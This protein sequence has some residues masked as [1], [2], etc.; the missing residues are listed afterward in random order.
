MSATT[1]FLLLASLCLSG[2]VSHSQAATYYVAK[3]GSDTTSCA[4]AQAPSTPRLTINRG[5]ACMR[6]GDTLLIGN[7]TYDE[8]LTDYGAFQVP[9][10][11]RTNHTP[12]PSGSAGA[13]TIL[14]AQ[15]SRQATLTMTPGGDFWA[16]I[17]ATSGLAYVQF[18]GFVIDGQNHATNGI[19]GDQP[20]NLRFYDLFLKDI[21]S[22]AVQLRGNDHQFL[23]IDME[24]IAW[25][26]A[27][28]S[29]CPH[30]TCGY[31]PPGCEGYCHAY[32]LGG[33][34]H[35]IDR[36]TIRNINGYLI[37]P[38]NAPPG[39]GSITITNVV[40]DGAS[41]IGYFNAG[42][43]LSNCTISNIY[44]GL[45]MS[46]GNTVAHNTMT[47]RTRR[48]ANDSVGV[49]QVGAG[50]PSMI[51]NNLIFGMD[52]DFANYDLIH[53]DDGAGYNLL[54]QGPHPNVRGNTCDKA[55][56]GCQ[57]VALAAPC[58]VVD[59]A[60]GDFRLCA[61]S[62]AIGAGVV[63]ATV[64]AMTP[65]QAGT[66]R[67]S[68][69]R[70]SGALG[71]LSTVSVAT[72]LAFRQQPSTTTL[73]QPF[74]PAVVVAVVDAAGKTVATSTAPITVALA[75][76]PGQATLEGCHDRPSRA[77]VATFTLERVDNCQWQYA[78]GDESRPAQCH[79][80]RV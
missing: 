31:G 78:P 63:D 11:Y 21:V 29:T 56:N 69:R 70:D 71:V 76:N 66:A 6:G 43:T 60:R 2:L 19:S 18:E 30:A 23:S 3:T 79:E 48:T 34:D 8:L 22:Q 10:H 14:K 27:G 35:V 17:E 59:A 75:A 42:S 1:R 80:H 33:Y 45:I 15:N 36:A 72:G 73:G 32:Y 4:A 5:L 53:V 16:P 46:A 40:L 38:Y 74:T 62:P 37:N 44:R 39:T 55:N 54:R 50:P 49:L 68:Q 7:G 58:F 51:K 9:A 13:Y 41:S 24:N 20:N 65:D 67:S 77:G 25:T 57:T 26:A 52:I 12:I 47:L 64:M 61:T 28:V